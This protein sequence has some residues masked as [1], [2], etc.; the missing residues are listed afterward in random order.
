MLTKGEWSIYSVHS[1]QK[2]IH[3]LAQLFTYCSHSIVLFFHEG[4]HPP[5]AELW[6]GPSTRL[7]ILSFAPL[8]HPTPP[9]NYATALF[10]PT[11]PDDCVAQ[12]LPFFHLHP[13][14]TP[15]PPNFAKRLCSSSRSCHSSICTPFASLFHLASLNN[16]V[17]QVLAFFRLHSSSTPLPPN[18][19]K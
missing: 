14:S 17:I 12:V 1:F 10:Y 19:A 4:F 2:M 11:P 13:S 7:T 16:C 3:F 6:L 8:F 5:S 15:L 9:D 18:S